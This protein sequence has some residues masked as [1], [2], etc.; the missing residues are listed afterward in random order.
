[1][2]DGS[3]FPAQP[4]WG[5]P[6]IGISPVPLSGSKTS[7]PQA[8]V[9]FSSVEKNINTATFKASILRKK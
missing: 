3:V 1:M 9:L 7:M 2:R 5:S 8:D 6:A 4:F